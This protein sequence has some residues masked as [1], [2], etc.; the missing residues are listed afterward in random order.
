[1]TRYLLDAWPARRR[2]ALLALFPLV[3]GWFLLVGR[4][5]TEPAPPAGW[6]LGVVVVAALGAAVLATYLPLAGRRPDLGCTPC[7]M[8][9]GLTLVGATTAIH[10]YDGAP[11]GLLFAAALLLFG[12]SQRMGRPATCEASVRPSR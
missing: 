6:Y 5:S 10:S 2:R 3:A 4:G 1:V 12:L 9:S 11:V 7:A 8:L